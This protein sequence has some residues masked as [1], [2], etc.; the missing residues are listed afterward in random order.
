MH[1]GTISVV[2]TVSSKA[3]TVGCF[4]IPSLRGTSFLLHDFDTYI[5]LFP[6]PGSLDGLFPLNL[7]FYRDYFRFYGYFV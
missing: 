3:Q 1:A 7:G 2:I 6:N 5:F 4:F